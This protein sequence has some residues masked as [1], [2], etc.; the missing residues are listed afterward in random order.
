MNNQTGM[1]CSVQNGDFNQKKNKKRRHL[2]MISSFSILLLIMGILML[3][4]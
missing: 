1:H 2:K 4:S 3:L